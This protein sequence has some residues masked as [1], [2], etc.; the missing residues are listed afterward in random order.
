MKISQAA[1][2]RASE[3]GRE[4]A[5]VSPFTIWEPAPGVMPKGESAN[6]MAMDYG[7][8]DVMSFAGAAG[9][10]GIGFLGFAYLA[11]LAQRPE[12]RRISETMAKEMTRKWIKLTIEGDDDKSEKLKA[13]KDAMDAFAVRDKFT[14]IAQHDGFSGRA[15]LFIDTGKDEADELKAP[16]V[17][18]RGKIAKGGLKALRVVEPFWAYP[19]GYNAISPLKPNFYRPQSWYVQGQEI[20]VSRFLT[21]IARDVPDI[22]KPGYAFAGLS[23]TQMAKP[24]VDKWIRTQKSVEDLIHSFSVSGIATNMAATLDGGG[25][26]SLFDRIDLFNRCRDNRGTMVLDKDTEEFFNVSTPLGTLDHL[27]AQAQEHI[28]SVVGIPLVILTGITPSGLNASSQDEIR[29]FYDWILAQEEHFF[30]PHLETVIDIIQLSTF[31][32]IDPAI[33]FEFVPLWQLDEAA[34][35]AVRKTDVDTAVEL[36]NAGVISPDEERVRVARAQDTAYAGLDLSDPAPGPPAQAEGEEVDD[37]ETNKIDA[38]GERAGG[39]VSGDEWN[40]T[41]HPRGQPENAGEFAPGGAPAETPLSV[42]KGKTSGGIALTYDPGARKFTGAS[43]GRIKALAIPPKWTS[44]RLSH[45]PAADLQVLALDAKG[46]PQYRY[47]EAFA[48]AN[49]ARKFERVGRLAQKG[50]ALDVATAAAVAKGS[51]TGAAVRL[52]LLT[53]MRPGGDADT[54]AEKRAFGATTLLK[55]HLTVEGEVVRYEFTGK[56]GVTIKN[57]VEDAVLARFIAGRLAAKDE[58]RVFSTNAAK[59]ND[60]VKAMAGEDFKCKDLRTLKANDI[61]TEMVNNMV[62]PSGAKARQ[63]A[64][65]SVADVVSKQL[66]NTRSVALADYIN[67]VVFTAWDADSAQ[68]EDE[69]PVSALVELYRAVSYAGNIRPVMAPADD[70]EGND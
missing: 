45:D 20:H 54:K 17:V 27:Q 39:G 1:L 37:P 3:G 63:A 57:E 52:M 46:R 59:A 60:L 68:A 29:V 9:Y 7:L 33:G 47:S 22:L 69:S 50:D 24:Y 49:K 42:S 21:F 58:D 11:E 44:V 14:E 35:A 5:P 61:A 30:R 10:E 55:N 62:A 31:G 18:H 67:P 38:E 2:A 66:G 28:A 41:D 4:T 53:G 48:L 12:Y 40:E 25:G 6:Q 64:I 34:K 56:K 13:L 43:P 15:H 51:G 26:A 8:A 19:A 36:I 16:L 65:N 23:L 32:E 70:D